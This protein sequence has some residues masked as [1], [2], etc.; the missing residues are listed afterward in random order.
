MTSRVG[1][2]M[3]EVA[4]AVAVVVIVV[5]VNGVAA[6]TVVGVTAMHEQ[7]LEYRTLPE[8]ADAYAGM[9]AGETV[10]WRTTSFLNAFATC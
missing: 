8:Q 6:V 10:A 3:S 5:V 2:A 4:V 7:A 9:L 1:R